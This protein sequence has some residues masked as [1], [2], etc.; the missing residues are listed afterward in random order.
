MK[1]GVLDYS[2]WRADHSCRRPFA[3]QI[4]WAISVLTFAAVT[5]SIAGFGVIFRVGYKDIKWVMLP[6]FAGM[7]VGGKG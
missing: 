4:V 7:V 1:W 5:A 6:R 3:F 2:N